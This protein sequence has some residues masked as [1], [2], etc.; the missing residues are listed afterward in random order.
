MSDW[1]RVV[2]TTIKNFIRGE[3]VNILRNRKLTAMLK[4]K[5]RITFNWGGDTMVWRVRYRRAPMQGYADSEVL[6][7]PRRDRWK[8]AELGWRGYAL[9]DSMTKQERLKNKSV[10]A[11][12]DIYGQI[13]KSLMDDAE[14]N[15]AEEMY[16]DGAAAGNQKRIHGI[17]TIFAGASD[18]TTNHGIVQ[19]SVTYAGLSTALGNYGGKWTGTWPNGYGD[20]HYD[21][22]SPLIVNYTDA[23]GWKDGSTFD[24][25]AI[26]VLR[27]AIIKSQKNKTQ[28][29][30]LDTIFLEGELYRFFL[31]NLQAI[32]RL[33]VQS[34][35]KNSTLIKLGFTDVQNFDGVDVTWEYGTPANTGY[36]FNCDQM[37]LRSMQGQLFVP[38]GPDYD[39]ASKSW[40][41]SIDFFGNLV[42]NPR[43]QVKLINQS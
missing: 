5:G 11:I 8:T 37:E 16:I 13:A 2:N 43:Y 9:T 7:F 41:F 31:A 3:E 12:I 20:A 23:T 40:R 24:L 32:Q 1:S 39:I 42:I 25:N 22:W 4:S 28:K 6:V 33:Y 38:E 19:P 17:E 14:E 30:R 21:F 35:E 29:G 36:G 27:Y 10:Q 18:T 26:E 34:N 15:F